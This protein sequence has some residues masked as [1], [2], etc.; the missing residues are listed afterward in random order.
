MTD[1]LG[2]YIRMA[3]KVFQSGKEVT[4]VCGDI[5]ATWKSLESEKMK[6]DQIKHILETSKV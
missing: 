1:Y 4:I 3:Q 6:I 2:K 5:E